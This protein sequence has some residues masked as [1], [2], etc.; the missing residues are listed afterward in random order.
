M[1][2]AIELLNFFSSLAKRRKKHPKISG[3][4]KLAPNKD[5]FKIIPHLK[6]HKKNPQC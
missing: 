5:S 6:S 3:T 4:S 2:E 1:A